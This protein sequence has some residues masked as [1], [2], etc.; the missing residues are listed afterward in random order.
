MITQPCKGAVEE[1]VGVSLY[2]REL[3]NRDRSNDYANFSGPKLFVNVHVYGMNSV[4]N[5]NLGICCSH[6]DKTIEEVGQ[7]SCGI[8]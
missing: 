8:G 2:A 7:V 5:E 3:P 6:F 1:G 4:S